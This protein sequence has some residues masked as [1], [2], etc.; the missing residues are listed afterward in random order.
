MPISYHIDSAHHLVRCTAKGV[1]TLAELTSLHQQLKGDK[2]CGQATRMLWD[3]TE[4]AKLDHSAA[5]FAEVAETTFASAGKRRA[6]VATAKTE[7]QK[8]LNIWILHREVRGDPSLK[9]FHSVAE[10]MHW[11]GDNIGRS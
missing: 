3:F 2:Q 7:T 5:K 8:L 9:L 11:L 6:L 1:I 4:A 10:A